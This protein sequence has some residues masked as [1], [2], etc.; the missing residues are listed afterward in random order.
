[1]GEECPLT[2][3][4]DSDCEWATEFVGATQACED[5]CCRLSS[6]DF[7]AEGEAASGAVLVTARLTVA[8]LLYAFVA[9]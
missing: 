5:G 9:V 2:C 1:M 8:L 7:N 4:A 3:S 6:T